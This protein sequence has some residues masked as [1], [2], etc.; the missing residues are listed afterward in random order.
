VS[1]EADPTDANVV[2]ISQMHAGSAFNVIPEK[3]QLRGAIRALSKERRNAALLSLERIAKGV[4]AAYRCEVSFEYYGSTPCTIN[5]PQM[6]EFVRQVAVGALGEKSFAW[7]PKPAMW[8]ED[9]A[10][11]LEQVPGCFFVLG[12]QPHDRD[13]YPMLHNPKYDFTDA[14]VPVGIR[15][16]TELAMRYLER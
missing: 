8:S 14:A 12:V 11:Y 2:T 1:R 13:S 3:A 16:M 7:A 5:D 9:F 10:C 6:A 15:M 4:G